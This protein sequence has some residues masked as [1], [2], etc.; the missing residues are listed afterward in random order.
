V[1]CIFLWQIFIERQ[2]MTLRP[3]RTQALHQLQ[4]GDMAPT[5]QNYNWVRRFTREGIQVQ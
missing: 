2:N 4:Q 5:I 3:R 1:G